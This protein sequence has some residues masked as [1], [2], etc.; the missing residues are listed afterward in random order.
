MTIC[1]AP[2]S[3]L[4][5]RRAME[6]HDTARPSDNGMAYASSSQEAKWHL[7]FWLHEPQA[8][9]A[10]TFNQSDDQGVVLGTQWISDNGLLYDDELEDTDFAKVLELGGMIS[11][12]STV[13]FPSS[14]LIVKGSAYNRSH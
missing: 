7:P 8:W 1:A 2:R 5:T 13:M 11:A 14:F 9:V 3:S 4:Y 6:S 10:T 12:R